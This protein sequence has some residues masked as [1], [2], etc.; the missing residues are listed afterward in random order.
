MRDWIADRQFEPEVE[1]ALLT[2]LMLA[3]DHVDSTAGT[4]MAF[5]K[6]PPPRFFE[7]LDLQ[8]PKLLPRAAAGKGLA[9]QMEAQEAATAL[10]GDIAYLDPPY[11]HHSY[12]G[13][14]HIWET[15]VRWDS[16]EAY[17]VAQKRMDTTVRKSDFNSKVRAAEALRSVIKKIDVGSLVLSYSNEGHIAP[18]AIVDILSSRGEVLVV[19]KDNKRYVGAQIGIHNPNGVKVGTPSHLRNKEML[20]V[21]PDPALKLGPVRARFRELDLR[22]GTRSRV[23]T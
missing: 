18:E 14:Y 12:L 13:N 3:A 17:G 20:F 4:Q 11:N 15:L 9:F 7:N 5:I 19:E 22:H 8:V 16:P 2:S 1:A 6:S 21:V 10:S 23:A